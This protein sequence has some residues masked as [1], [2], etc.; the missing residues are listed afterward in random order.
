[1]RRK[2]RRPRRPG[3]AQA[4]LRH[5]D[6]A[7]GRGYSN[8]GRHAAGAPVAPDERAGQDREGIDGVVEKLPIHRSSRAH[9]RI[10]QVVDGVQH[11]GH[12]EDLQHRRRRRPLRAEHGTHELRRDDGH[13]RERGKDDDGRKAYR[14]EI[15]APQALGVSLDARVGREQHRVQNRG[16]L[17]NR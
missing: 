4:Q 16:E 10:G 3:Q 7:E 17:V 6:I 5:Q 13:R 9:Q 15:P 14:S 8:G 11:P 2:E 12:A 1:M